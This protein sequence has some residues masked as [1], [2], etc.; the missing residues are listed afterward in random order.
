MNGIEQYLSLFHEE[1]TSIF[2]YLDDF[3]VIFDKDYNAVL[4]NKIEDIN[5]FYNARKE[6]ENLE[7]I[8]AQMVGT[9]YE[10]PNPDAKPYAKVGD[11]IKKGQ[12]I[13]IIEAMKIFNEIESDHDGEIAEILVSDSSPVEFNQPLFSIKED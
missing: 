3:L 6:D 9:F 11:T 12:I 13:C 1:L 10:S 2:S 5:D 8:Q 7:Q 4:E